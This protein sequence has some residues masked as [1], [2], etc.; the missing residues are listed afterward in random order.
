MKQKEST[1][2]QKKMPEDNSCPIPGVWLR[3]LTAH[4]DER[5]FFTEVL[6]ESDDSGDFVQINHSRS[7]AGVL[8]ALHFHR[9][10]ADLWH[11]AAGQLQVGLA[12]LRGGSGKPPTWMANISAE[13]PVCLFIPPG[14][15]HGFLALERVDLIYAV[16]AEYDPADEFG[17]AWDDP[18]LALD[19]H[20]D[21]PILSKR[22]NTNPELDWAK[23]SL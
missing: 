5:G 7:N 19:W 14:V 16:T 4:R 18:T 10:Q 20:T 13:Q 6:K 23:I 21:D 15:A 9:K 11:V 3:E 22:D 17:I 2:M 12:D 1:L 8:R